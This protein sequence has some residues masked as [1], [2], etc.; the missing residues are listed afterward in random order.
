MDLS[1]NRV[2]CITGSRRH[3]CHDGPTDDGPAHDGPAD[4][5]PAHDGPAH[6]GPAHDGPSGRQLSANY[7]SP[8][9]HRDNAVA[10]RAP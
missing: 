5:G 4:D 6:D 10:A 8:A 9:Q 7:T 1:G 2:S 3:V